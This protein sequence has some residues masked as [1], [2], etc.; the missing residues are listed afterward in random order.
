VIFLKKNDTGFTSWLSVQK[1]RCDSQGEAMHRPQPHLGDSVFERSAT[2][3]VP[4]W[5]PLQTRYQCEKK[6]DTALRDNGFESFAPMRLETRRWSDRTKLVESPLFP[7]YMFVR[8]LA[9]PK[10]LT[11][12]LRLPGMVRFVTVG[13]ELVAVPNAEMETVRALTES[14]ASCEPA[15]FPA[16]GERV[17]IHGG[18]LEGVEGVLTGQT[19]HR[20]IVISV[21]AIQRSLKIPLGGYQV[22]RLL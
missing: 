6:V 2:H 22:E 14:D 16:V 9:D 3:R 20:E 5:Y 12:V 21:G 10:L 19:G 18:C 17:R 4:A 8:M 15:P 7:G 1:P 11:T 13:R